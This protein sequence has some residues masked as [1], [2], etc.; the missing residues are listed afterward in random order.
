MNADF[1]LQV[2]TQGEIKKIEI[3][4]NYQKKKTKFKNAICKK[5]ICNNLIDSVQTAS[6]FLFIFQT[7]FKK[8]LIYIFKSF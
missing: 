3:K 7:Y 1:D 2:S 4:Q 8:K 5:C 6:F